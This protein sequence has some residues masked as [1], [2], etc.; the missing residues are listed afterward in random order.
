[1]P[2]RFPKSPM[3]TV[4]VHRQ[5]IEESKVRDSSHCM[6]SEAI[7]LQFPYAKSVATDLQTI[8]FS[9][10]EKRLRYTYLTPRIAQLA[11]V[12]FDQGETPE[13]FQFRLGG[14]HVTDMA[15]R[16]SPDFAPAARARTPAQ[17]AAM[18]KARQAFGLGKTTL[19][20]GQSAKGGVP[21]RVGGRTPPTTPFARRR[22]FGLRGLKP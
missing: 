7:K 15:K 11:L 17:V 10:P 19:R 9:N 5:L 6:I 3:G 2:R 16:K 20:T 22:A 18:D 4:V 12:Q 14:G 13:P 1:M 21:E 8:R